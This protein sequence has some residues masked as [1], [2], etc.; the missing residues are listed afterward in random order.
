VEPDAAGLASAPAGR[1][2]KV[3]AAP[4]PTAA[5]PVGAHSTELLR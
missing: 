4:L 3:P 2:D 5:M 1:T